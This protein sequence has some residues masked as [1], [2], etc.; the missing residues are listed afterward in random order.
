MNRLFAS[1]L[2]L[3]TVGFAA[4]AGAQP[5]RTEALAKAKTKFEAD[6]SKAEDALIATLDKGI[7]K[8]QSAGNKTMAEKLTYERELFVNHRIVP[9]TIATGAYLKQRSQATAALEAVYNPAI[10]ELVKAKKD[11]EAEAL[12]GALS[13]LLKTARGY[14]M[15]IP[16]LTGRPP[17]VIENKATGQVIEP[18]DKDYWQPVVFTAKMGKRRPLQCWYLDREEKGCTFV[19]AQSGKAMSKTNHVVDKKLVPIV[20]TATIDPQKETP[21]N[22][23][24][25]LTETRREVVITSLAKGQTNGLVLTVVEK[26]Q[27]GVTIY[28]LAFEKKE[29]PP[30]PHQLWIISE[31]K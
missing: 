15:A 23:L 25:E 16:D 20:A 9:T 5:D 6:I 13:G 18:V 21:D 28:E 29:S 19:N 4:P 3:L 17:I 24:F 10:K 8:A 2:F 14:G 22:L 31:A 30:T 1:L 27:K 26:K 7:M 12:E 11:T